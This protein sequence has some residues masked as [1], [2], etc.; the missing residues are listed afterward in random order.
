M[1]RVL[2]R[3]EECTGC[4]WGSRRERGQWGKPDVDERIILRRIFRKLEWVV[5][6]RKSLLRIG[7]GGGHL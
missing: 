5:G 1:W 4:W 7:S 3:R 2:E 6:T